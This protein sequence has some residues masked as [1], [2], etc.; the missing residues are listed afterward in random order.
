MKDGFVL[1]F[2]TIFL[3][4]LPC[5]VSSTDETE[6]AKTRQQSYNNQGSVVSGIFG[7]GPIFLQANIKNNT[8]SWSKTT[9]AAIKDRFSVEYSKRLL[10]HYCFKQTKRIILI[11]VRKIIV[12][13]ISFQ[14]NL[15]CS[16]CWPIIAASDHKE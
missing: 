9:I 16:Y 13:D 8:W 12:K 11:L 14:Q 10:D 4:V 5:T 3:T 6:L 7:L 15:Y 1:V 2:V